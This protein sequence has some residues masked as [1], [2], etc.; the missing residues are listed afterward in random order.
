MMGVISIANSNDSDHFFVDIFAAVQSLLSNPVLQ[1]L[2]FK[3]RLTQP[4]A[5]CWSLFVVIKPTARVRWS[6]YST[7]VSLGTTTQT[8]QTASNPSVWHVCTCLNSTNS[9]LREIMFQMLTCTTATQGNIRISASGR[10]KTT[11]NYYS[12]WVTRVWFMSI[13]SALFRHAATTS[14]RH[15]TLHHI[16]L[17]PVRF[18]QHSQI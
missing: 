12:S 8:L 17:S 2:N 14:S 9:K 18:R 1:Y 11:L 16:Q 10:E 4:S 6:L 3:K 7:S 15:P 5:Q 13:C